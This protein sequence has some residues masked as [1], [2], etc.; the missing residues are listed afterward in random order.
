MP[1]YPHDLG[2]ILVDHGSKRVE[3]NQ[4]LEDV[5]QLFR[6]TTGAR[7]VEIAHMELTEPTIAQAFARCAAQGAKRVVVHPYF[8][9]P[10]RHST[11]DI[12]R[13]VADAA[14]VC[15]GVAYTVTAPLGLD[16]RMTDI[17]RD[18]IALAMNSGWTRP[19][20]GDAAR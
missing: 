17:I 12:P 14:A 15:P 5:A 19:T 9:A 18:R 2:I 10:G 16:P 20:D 7:I 6:G 1:E 4:L 8:L 11:S 3:A 13:L